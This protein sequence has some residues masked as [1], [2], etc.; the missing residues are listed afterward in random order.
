MGFPVN[1]VTSLLSLPRTLLGPF[2]ESPMVNFKREDDNM[3][4]LLN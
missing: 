4:S 3:D 2:P 1:P